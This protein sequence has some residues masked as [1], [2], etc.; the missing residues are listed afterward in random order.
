MNCGHCGKRISEFNVGSINHTSNG[1][2]VIRCRNC[3]NNIGLSNAHE[4][5]IVP[6]KENSL[7]NILKTKKYYYPM[8]YT[9]RGGFYLAFYCKGEI[10]YY[11]KVKKTDINIRKKNLPYNV[12]IRASIVSQDADTLYRVYTLEPLLVLNKPFIGGKDTSIRNVK[13][14]TLKK[15]FQA[16]KINDL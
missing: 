4:V 14:T 12:P 13:N 11:A 6:V 8:R 9:R 7:I 15:L 5:M 3:F 10:K 2:L 1:A 16:E